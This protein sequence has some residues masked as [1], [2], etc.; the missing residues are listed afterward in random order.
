MFFPFSN[1]DKDTNEKNFL[2]PNGP[3]LASAISGNVLYF[4]GNFNSLCQVYSPFAEID[5]DLNVYPANV[6]A[7]I[8]GDSI[9]HTKVGYE[10]DPYGNKYFCGN[11]RNVNNISQVCRPDGSTSTSPANMLG[12][13]E[14]FIQITPSGIN[15][16]LGM[17]MG[18]GNAIIGLKWVGSG[19]LFR[20]A[21][22]NIQV[23]N[24]NNVI[25]GANYGF[26][27]YNPSIV[28]MNLEV[29]PAN[30]YR[31]SLIP[32]RT[33]FQNFSNSTRTNSNCNDYFVD[34]G[35]FYPNRTGVWVCGNFTTAAGGS[36]NRIVCLDYVSGTAITGFTSAAGPNGEI[37][38]MIRSGN[39]IY[40][41]GTFTT[42]GGV[43]R[44]RIAAVTFPDMTL[45]PF[46]PNLNGIVRSMNTG[47]SGLYIGGDFTTVAGTGGNYQ[48]L[49]RVDYENGVIMTGFR[50]NSILP[51][52]LCG[53]V[54][55]FGNK[56]I[57]DLRG[58]QSKLW[59]YRV[60]NSTSNPTLIA[61]DHN[62]VNPPYIIDNVSGLTIH[63]GLSQG[64][65]GNSYY[66]GSNGLLFDSYQKR[67]N[68]MLI[69]GRSH[70]GFIEKIKRNNA[71]AVDLNTNRILDW[72][73][74]IQMV[75]APTSNYSSNN[76]AQG[77]WSMHLDTGDNTLA[78]GGRFNSVNSPTL[79]TGIRNS[80]AIVDLRT[81]GL[82]TNFN[83][84]LGVNTDILC[85]E[86]SGN[87]LFMGGNFVSGSVPNRI[88]SFAGIDINTNQVRYGTNFEIVQNFG[89]NSNK[90]G[91]SS[92]SVISCMRRQ[93]DRLYVGGTFGTVSGLSRNG[94]FC[95][96]LQNN[97]ITNFNLNLDRE[98]KA[99]DIDTS[100][101]TLYIGG[102]FRRVLG[103]E[104]N[105]GAAINLNNTG[106]LAWDP[107]LPREPTNI[108]VT[109]S[110][111]LVC[112]SFAHAGERRGGIATFSI[113]SGTLLDTPVLSLMLN[114]VGAGRTIEIY[115]NNAYINGTFNSLGISVGNQNFTPYANQLAYNL[116]SGNLVTGNI[117][118][119]A[120][121]CTRN[122]GILSSFLESGFMY[123]GGQFTLVQ[124]MSPA[125][126]N[127]ST[128][129]RNRV[130]WF[131][132]NN[133]RISGIDYNV[134]NSVFAIKRRDN[135]LYIG[136]TFTSVL[137]T[138]RNRIARINLNDNT[139]D[140]WNPNMNADVWDLQF[141][142]NKM[143]ACGDFT[144]VSGLSRNRICRFDVSAAS[145]GALESY[146]PSILN[147]VLRKMAITGNTIYTAGTT[148]QFG[149]A[150]VSAYV[151]VAAFDTNT[152]AHLTTF[153]PFSGYTVNTSYWYNTRNVLGTDGIT[154]LH[155]HPSGLFVGGDLVSVGGSGDSNS[156][157]GVFLVGLTS[158]NIIR[159]YGGA[160][161]GSVF[162]ERPPFGFGD[163]FPG[164]IWDIKTYGDELITVGEFGDMLEY[165]HMNSP[166]P[167][168][169]F[170][171]LKDKITGN[172]LTNYD[173]VID[174][175][176]NAFQLNQELGTASSS[177]NM[178]VYDAS[179]NNDR[180]YFHGLFSNLRHPDFR[181]STAAM[182]YSGNLD[183]N[184]KGFGV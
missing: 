128:V 55:E 166:S 51:L 169:S 87:V 173:F 64:C 67:G 20:H 52:G 155:L 184:F 153:R 53:Y 103:Q 156:P 152:A 39:K 101:N 36:W 43:T 14:S 135:F 71:F 134:N 127:E 104:R 85:L 5:S 170:I 182:D 30:N 91:P 16:G 109:P 40:F 50:P 3:V 80:V 41:N 99:M 37:Y 29:N 108:R 10:V 180:I 181:C 172:N 86:K 24:S 77:I 111:V 157:R 133:Q 129:T 98:V 174:N 44:N 141:S 175:Q 144:T 82:T 58:D 57:V 23:F 84:D 176:T 149:A 94:L 122:G 92:N 163:Q 168:N 145:G 102:A 154:A 18:G 42:V 76:L 100:T 72:N 2:Y 130:A 161:P 183:K 137:G 114:Q 69:F 45:L 59:T 117:N 26:G 81:G 110:G 47:V 34:T 46:N 31:W 49:C 120:P 177:A 73:P 150:P 62:P 158:G 8:Y 61:N 171:T 121:R 148:S 142:G 4:G 21:G 22:N 60:N 119:G 126:S 48:F 151:G 93:N 131:D 147:G 63:T 159:N 107:K 38:S 106:L 9:G 25:N 112:G 65:G 96:D 79:T 33:W 66:H 105:F 132:L 74:N 1:L 54:N 140:S 95:L 75:S 164:Q 27:L 118:N 113:Q 35:N 13:R 88:R 89:F 17:A 78:I 138:A 56:V 136:G 32:D 12:G 6:D 178:F 68:N 97:S 139:L 125:T 124:N 143:F 11:F 167:Q 19:L 162:R 116:D 7:K 165:R 90:T 83:V 70:G 179:F 123:I 15:T 28:K 146:N 115:N 160:G